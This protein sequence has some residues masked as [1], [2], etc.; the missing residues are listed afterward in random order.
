[1]H[2]I[3]DYFDPKDSLFYSLIALP[4]VALIVYFLS[5]KKRIILSILVTCIPTI[6]FMIVVIACL[7]II[8]FPIDF[9]KHVGIGMGMVMIPIYNLLWIPPA[10]L[11]FWLGKVAL[12]LKKR[13]LKRD[14]RS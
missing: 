10:L 13:R 2:I 11:G 7:P 12:W 8:G 1:M 14:R 5:G 9:T 4:L 6:I 3:A